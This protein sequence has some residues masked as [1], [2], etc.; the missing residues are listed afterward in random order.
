MNV[1][2]RFPLREVNGKKWCSLANMGIHRID[3]VAYDFAVQNKFTFAGGHRHRH[4]VVRKDI[5][6]LFPEEDLK[7]DIAAVRPSTPPRRR[8]DRRG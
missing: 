1:S 4:A 8:H 2:L 3:V 7:V 6:I 5:H